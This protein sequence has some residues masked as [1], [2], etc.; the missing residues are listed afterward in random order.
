MAYVKNKTSVLDPHD[1]ARLASLRTIYLQYVLK[2]RHVQTAVAGTRTVHIRIQEV[3]A[4]VQRW[5]IPKAIL[6]AVGA[7]QRIHPI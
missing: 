3:T 2:S 5:Q 6:V 4:L 1:T 7:C